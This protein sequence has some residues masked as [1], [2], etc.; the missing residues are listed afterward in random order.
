M[1]NSILDDLD[2]DSYIYRIFSIERLFQLFDTKKNVLV[3]PSKWDDPFENCILN[4]QVQIASGNK[5]KF[6][7]KEDVYGQCWTSRRE[8]DAMWRIYS[9]D[10]NGVRV[11]TTVRK[12][13]EGLR[14]V[15]YVYADISC[16][17]GKVKYLPQK[18]FADLN[19]NVLDTSGRGIADTLL[20][21]RME[22]NHEKEIRLIYSRPNSQHT[23]S[24]IFS[25]DFFPE[26]IIN[27]I[28]F[29]P[30][31]DKRMSDVY[32]HSLTTVYSFPEKSI[33]K[34]KLYTPPAEFITKLEA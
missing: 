3:H 32:K 18:K 28:T 17:I 10:K 14:Q 1:N 30:R 16:F 5:G 33:N 26:N 15:E 20:Y 27:E 24:R 11:R 34:S 19:I 6:G 2:V 22:F 21:K 7:F 29:D 31:I 25:Y 9:P 23:N 4:G 8:S 12:L 13:I